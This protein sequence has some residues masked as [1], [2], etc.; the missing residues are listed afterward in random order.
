MSLPSRLLGANPS[1]QVSTLLTG[2]LSTPSAK[3]TFTTSDFQY[4]AGTTLA[5]ASQNVTFSN[6]TTDFTHLQVRIS[7]RNAGGDAG[8]GLRFNG[9]T[10]AGNYG[11]MRMYGNGSD[12]SSDAYVAQTPQSSTEDSELFG[13]AIINIPNYRRTNTFKTATSFSGYVGAYQ[14]AFMLN[15]IWKVTDA[16]TSMTFTNQTMGGTSSQA[17]GSMISIYGLV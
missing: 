12:A 5:S 3:G 2:S 10:T 4:I 7:S 15:Q 8:L 1:I 13:Y 9:D 17:A 16:I 11:W 14:A 6:L